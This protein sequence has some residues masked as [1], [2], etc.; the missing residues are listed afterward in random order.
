M[1]TLILNAVGA[2]VGGP[3]GAAIGA[4]IGQAIDR[5]IFAPK[6]RE[7]PR[8]ADLSLQSSTYGARL[9]KLFGRM[10]LA[11]TVIWATDLKEKRSRQSTGKGQPKAAVYSY[12]AS[13]AVA[14]SSRKAQRIGR[15]WADGKLLRGEAGDFK[16]Q[17]GFRFHS[18][19]ENQ[20]V[21]PH[22]AATE[23]MGGTPAYRGLAYAVFENMEL[24]DFGNR[25]PSITFEVIADETPVS[26]G[27]IAQA[28]SP[29]EIVAVCPTALDGFAASGD[30]VRGVLET[31]ANA[32]P[33]FVDD[34]GQSLTLREM[35]LL[36]SAIAADDLGTSA[37][38]KSVA[39]KSMS[40]LASAPA[41][42][43]LA[44]RHYDPARDYQ[45]GLQRVWRKRDGRADEVIELPASLSASAALLLA[46]NRIAVA[47]TERSGADIT[48]PWRYLDLRPGQLVALPGDARTFRLGAVSLQAMVV[49]A[50]LTLHHQPELAAL[51]SGSGRSVSAADLIH[52]ATRLLLIDLPNLQT[53]V[54]TAPQLFAAAA[55]VLPGWRRAQLL[56]SVDDGASWNEVGETAA[57][58]V[59]GKV[60][61]A[62]PAGQ[63]YITDHA[64]Q[65]TVDL[66]H[67]GMMLA[68]TDIDGLISGRNLALVGQELIQFLNVDMLS[69]TTARLTGLVRGR[70]GTEWAM[71]VHGANEDF[72]LIDAETL[73]ALAVPVGASPIR[74]I[75]SGLG[76][77]V[78]VEA[79]ALNP[80][81]SLIPL[82]P[83]QLR[84]APL[85]NGDTHVRWTRR[86][87]DGWRWLD[88]V[89]APLAEET[90]GYS[91]TL[92]P[93]VGAVR[94]IAVAVPSY[95]YTA[96]EKA[97]DIAGGA[98]ALQVGV[99]QSGTFSTSRVSSITITLS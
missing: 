50:G 46:E 33:I 56:I 55:G 92:T 22:I 12:S 84:A 75:A 19:D 16:S 24:A 11:G 83:V 77:T 8:L 80:N 65:L 14:L 68:A 61:T 21:D 38:G 72:V 70:R 43:A 57:P 4:V 31:L 54:A 93:D 53:G 82:S 36:G 67:S 79:I 40:R 7:G 59:L 9:P 10:R 45:I 44:I 69:A 97:A 99:S 73:A 35:P 13:F 32:V 64:A 76:D 28:I 26:I 52:G 98:S 95:V 62:L 51:A 87:R 66:G 37:D 25:I 90:E 86:S 20:P 34:D 71:P 17:T 18:G 58:A 96:A 30:S 63:P 88:G 27:D 5:R 23:G 49:N 6:G 1:A 60:A 3:I 78:P 85:A 29:I 42:S 48:L 94:S 41:P 91:L 74:V 81:A 89:D 2:A 15:I 39:S 47:Q